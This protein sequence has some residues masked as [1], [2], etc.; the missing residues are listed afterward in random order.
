MEPFLSNKF[1]QK[2]LCFALAKYV[3]MKRLVVTIDNM[4]IQERHMYSQFYGE[5]PSFLLKSELLKTCKMN[6]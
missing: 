1:L 2:L 4:S 5:P 3:E 6:R